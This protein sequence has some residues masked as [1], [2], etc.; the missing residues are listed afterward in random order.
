ME[1]NKNLNNEI[2]EAVAGIDPSEMSQEEIKKAIGDFLTKE[3]G[4]SMI[5][6]YRVAC[7]TVLQMIAPWHKPNCSHREYERIFKRLEEFCGKAL[8]RDDN[9]LE[10][11]ETVQNESS[12]ESQ[13]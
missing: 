6:G 1:E 11:S 10:T 9:E 7:Q 5:L 4:Q 8:K 13:E 2:D 3:R 12:E